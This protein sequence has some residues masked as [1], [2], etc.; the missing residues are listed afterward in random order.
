MSRALSNLP[1]YEA[2]AKLIGEVQGKQIV[3]T[4][5]L[6]THPLPKITNTD[7]VAQAIANGHTLCQTREAIDDEI[8]TR[9]SRWGPGGNNPP[10]QSGRL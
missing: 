3:R 9:Q 1:R 6:Q 4:H 8:R 7:M 5:S 10:Q 2:Y